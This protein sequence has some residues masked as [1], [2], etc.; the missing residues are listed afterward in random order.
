M[1][2][3]RPR[4]I[5]PGHGPT[6]FDAVG[7]IR[8]YE[9]HRAM[10]ERQA[11]DALATG[12]RTIAELVTEIYADTPAELHPAAALQLEALMTKL[13]REERVTRTGSGDGARFDPAVERPC[14][15][16]GRPAMPR[17]ML[18]RRCSLDALQ[19]RA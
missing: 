9:E 18:C 4:V 16:C 11:L 2:E 1:R 12:P 17:S 7:K 13:E 19:E 10:R 14:V 8:E 3:A 6:V 15:L 5:Y